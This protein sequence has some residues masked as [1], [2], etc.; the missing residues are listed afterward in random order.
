MQEAKT[1]ANRKAQGENNDSFFEGIGFKCG[2]EVHQRLLTQEKLFCGC[3]AGQEPDSELYTIERYQRAVAGELGSLDRAALFEELKKKKFVYHLFDRKTCL[4]DI[5]EEPPREMNAVALSI[6]ISVASALNMHIL[7]E[8]EPMRKEV[9]D[10]SNPTAFQRTTVVGIDGFLDV[11]RSRIDIPMLSLEEE[12]SGIRASTDSEISYDTDR[13]GIPLVEIDTGP[14]IKS[15]REAKAVALYIGTLLRLTMRVQRGI[16]TIRQDV[17]VSVRGGARIEI[18]GLQDL[19]N[20]DKFVENEVSRQLALIEISKELVHRKAT[21]DEDIMDVSGIFKST[22]AKIL[23][24]S[25]GSAI[26]AVGLRGFKGMLGK[27]VNPGRRLGTEISD[28]A[29]MGGVKG[30]IHG[31]ENLA[32][33]G[34]SDSEIAELERRLSISEKDSFML[35]AARHETAYKSMAVAAERARQAIKGIPEETRAAINDGKFQTKFIR[36]LPG[37][38]R[39]Y[40]ET[41]ARPVR[42]TGKILEA[43]KASAPSVE[44]EMQ[45]LESELESRELARQLLMSP[46]L[47]VYKAVTAETKADKEFVANFLIQ[48]LTEL[49]R[50]GVNIDS[51]S[52]GQIADIF[53]LYASHG[54]T[55]NGVEEVFKLFASGKAGTA[56]ELAEKNGLK[57]ISGERLKRLVAEA[58][59]GSK[60]SESELIKEI[61]SRYRLVVDGQEVRDAIS[62]HS[63]SLHRG[64]S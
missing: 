19:D 52:E 1:Q 20:M 13:V 25:P 24:Q 17:N 2:L 59:A 22:K 6:A 45:G 51:V 38:A 36:P 60:R 16:G 35:I 32:G 26:I 30:L 21:V 53:A 4:V 34:I 48:K 61:M 57:R 5:D 62:E 41:D 40:P 3:S 39:M 12:S 18:K 58:Y 15:P 11:G 49:R 7:D 63:K 37:G 42:I 33:Y 23:S 43:A 46:R 8:L 56:S 31:D 64:A 9:V 29:K 44:R 55:K 28:Y 14:T 27:E 54:L 47:S 50:S 10:G